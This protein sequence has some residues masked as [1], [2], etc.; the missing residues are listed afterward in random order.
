MKFSVQ[1]E[2]TDEE[3]RTLAADAARRGLV[4]GLKYLDDAMGRI[5]TPDATRNLFAVLGPIIQQVQQQGL[6]GPG[7][8]GL[9]PVTF[10]RRAAGPIGPMPASPPSTG[11]PAS[12]PTGTMVEHC[13]AI[14]ES[15]N[16][17]AG[18]GCHECATFNA[19]QRIACRACGHKKCGPI[20][21]PPPTP[22]EEPPA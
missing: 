19:A 1:A 11:R 20:V 8:P 17:E 15:R 7:G 10:F 4:E 21:T 5:F 22:T 2:A 9:G 14:E 12:V 3:I 18:W 6:G 13:F 16:T